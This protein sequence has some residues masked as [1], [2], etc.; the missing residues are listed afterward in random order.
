MVELKTLEPYRKKGRKKADNNRLAVSRS[1][2]VKL[3]KKD[4]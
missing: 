1:H 2:V 4:C 3:K